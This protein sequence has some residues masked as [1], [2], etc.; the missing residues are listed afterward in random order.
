MEEDYHESLDS[1]GSNN[2]SNS[3]TNENDTVKDTE[4]L[5]DDS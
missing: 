5:K 2:G 1:N 3:I 4:N